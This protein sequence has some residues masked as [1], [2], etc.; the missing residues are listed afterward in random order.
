VLTRA[1]Y[2]K[3]D[4]RTP[5][6]VSMAMVLLN[7]GL[8]V[9]LIWPFREAGLAWATSITATVQCGVLM[10]L[11]RHRIGG[12]LPVDGDV[13]QGA[14]RIALATA[15][16]AAAVFAALW[17]L[18]PRTTWWTQLLGVAVGAGAGGAVFAAAARVLRI[19]EFGWLLS[20]R[21]R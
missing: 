14:A 9:V 15:V 18:G 2:A 19:E 21:R 8:N 7:I 10:V 4:T 17:L 6:Y 5:M 12:R 16:M 20:L 3:H 1:F 11:L 13:V